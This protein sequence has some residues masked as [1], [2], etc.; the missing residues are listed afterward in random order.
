MTIIEIGNTTITIRSIF[1]CCN[2]FDMLRII[3]ATDNIIP[4]SKV[5]SHIRP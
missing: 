1:L 5:A 3:L 4:I 2:Y